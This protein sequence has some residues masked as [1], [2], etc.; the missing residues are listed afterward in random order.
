MHPSLCIYDVL[1]VFL[2]KNGH[3]LFLPSLKLKIV[4]TVREAVA[5]MSLAY[6]PK[7]AA[8]STVIEVCNHAPHILPNIRHPELLT[9][10]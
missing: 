4:V 1:T 8:N 7:D 2:A 6:L 9:L 3:Q 5:V 10:T